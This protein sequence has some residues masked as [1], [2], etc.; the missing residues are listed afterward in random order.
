MRAVISIDMEHDCPPFLQSYRGMEQGAPRFLDLLGAEDIRATFF[1]TGDVARRYPDTMRR[2]VGDG[3]ELAS[4]GDTHRRF[5]TMTRSEA[6]A[7]IAASLDVLSRYVTITSF[8]AP[9]LDFPDP[10][11]PLLGENGITLDSSLAAYKR[12]K[13]HPNRPVKVGGLLRIPVSTTPSATR[14]PG[15]IR[16]FILGQQRDPVMLFFHPWEFVDL[17]KAPIPLDCRFRTGDAAL[18]GLR[19]SIADLRKRGAHFVTARELRHGAPIAS[20]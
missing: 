12:H 3:H 5:G 14:L 11:L 1:C 2:I 4:H 15:P 13:G 8:R 9:N 17:R 10:F 16:R 19:A 20:G 18:A 7:E 6:A